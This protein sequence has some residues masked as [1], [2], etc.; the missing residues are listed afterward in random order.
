MQ[1]RTSLLTS[2]VSAGR[3]VGC[4]RE[5]LVERTPYAPRSG[6]VA[7]P[8]KA[9]YNLRGGSGGANDRRP[10]VRSAHRR[11]GANCFTTGSI[12]PNSW[13]ARSPRSTGSTRCP[14][15]R[16]SPATSSITA[17]PPNTSICAR[18]WHHS[19]CRSSSFP[20]EVARRDDAA[21]LQRAT[22]LKPNLAKPR[23]PSSWPRVSIGTQVRIHLQLE[24]CI[25][26]IPWQIRSMRGPNRR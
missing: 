22:S 11:A 23:A 7:G 9:I 19:R 4:T 10:A 15:S 3:R 18:C 1:S 6:Q 14:M 13:R 5:L 16:S 12:P 20:G 2:P 21:R 25:F 17:T 26:C 24:Q 8:S